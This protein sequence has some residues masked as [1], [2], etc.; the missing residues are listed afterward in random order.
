MVSSRKRRRSQAFMSSAGP[1]DDAGGEP[2]PLEGDQDALQEDAPQPEP[3]VETEERQVVLEVD[4]KELTRLQAIW[5]SFTEEFH[6]TTEQLPLY[7]HRLFALLREQDEQMTGNCT[8]MLNE[9]QKY[10][11]LR[12]SLA[13][14]IVPDASTNH[15]DSEDISA[16]TGGCDTSG[17]PNDD[18]GVARTSLS[19]SP[20]ERRSKRSNPSPTRRPSASGIPRSISHQDARTSSAVPSSANLANQSTTRGLLGHIATL[21]DSILHASHEKFNLAVTAYD[22]VDRH[23]RLLDQAIKEQETS[24][25]L[26]LRPGTHAMFLPEVPVPRSNRP[27]RMEPSPALNLDIGAD[28]DV[29]GEPSVGLISDEPSRQKGRSSLRKGRKRLKASATASA[30]PEKPLSPQH[31]HS[32]KLRVPPLS[33]IQTGETV[34]PNEPK[35]CYCHDVSHG[36]VRPIH[37]TLQ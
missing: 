13:R 34:D 22:S 12:R 2:Q 23:I 10:I 33:T 19:S 32:I 6:E 8:E 3:E 15:E 30:E 28:G 4:E 25:S 20:S 18:T 11:S 27:P 5:D 29:E 36:N 1:E 21:S 24:I 35:Y 37:A 7:L 9:L 16:P 26:G 17:P 14:L 31:S